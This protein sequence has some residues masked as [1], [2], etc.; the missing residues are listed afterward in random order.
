[1]YD[2]SE[3]KK[4]QER[5]FVAPVVRVLM[6]QNT[7][8]VVLAVE[9]Y[10]FNMGKEFEIEQHIRTYSNP[11]GVGAVASRDN[12]KVLATLGH[13]KGELAVYNTFI[14]SETTVSPFE[15][16]LQNIEL[17]LDVTLQ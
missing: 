1:M 2:G 3:R 16:E 4:L 9:I 7:L 17:S 5:H 13:N 11:R 8:V 10:V 14:N 12:I 15:T 6:A